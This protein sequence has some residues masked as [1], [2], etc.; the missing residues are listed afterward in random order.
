MTDMTKRD[1][2]QVL[3]L[4]RSCDA[5]DI[6]KAYRKKALQHHPDRNPGNKEAEEKFK[7]AAE[8]YSVLCDPQKRS[9]YD[10]YGH[11]GLRGEGFAGFEGFDSTIFGD[12]QDILGSFFGFTFGDFFGTT[13]RSARRAAQ[14]GRDLALEMEVT[15]EDVFRGAERE[16]TLNRAESCPACQG[17]RLRPGTKKTTCPA[18]RGQ[19]HIR[20]QQGFFTVSQT[21]PQCRGEGEI[22]SSPCAE[23][24]GTGRVKKKETLTIRLPAGIDDGA[25]LR[26]VGEGEAGEPG[27][28]R[29]DLYVV[30]HVK[31]HDVFERQNAD[32]YCQVSISFSQAA[33]GAVLEFFTLNGSEQLKIPTGAQSGEMIKL[34]GKGLK[35]IHSQGAGDLYVRLQVRTPDKLTREEKDLLRQL[36][37][38]QNEPQ[39][40]VVKAHLD[41]LGDIVH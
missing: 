17:T 7:E 9:I 37:K 32:L 10:R 20:H 33:L 6:K 18:C 12:F 36:S 31:K 19:G 41:K 25:R 16:V 27:A 28:P 14:A 34:K 5:E 24:R 15:L 23:C 35:E 30:V 21:C 8:A 1:Y 40:E 22:V 26:L 29:G 38:L 4:S 2:Y 39:S 3:D 13:R 11:D